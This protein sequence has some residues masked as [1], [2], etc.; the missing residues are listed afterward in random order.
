MLKFKTK[1]FFPVQYS[2]RPYDSKLYLIHFENAASNKI[3]IKKVKF[4][5]EGKAVPNKHSGGSL[6]NFSWLTE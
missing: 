5:I 1:A 2:K 3:K 6:S 4:N